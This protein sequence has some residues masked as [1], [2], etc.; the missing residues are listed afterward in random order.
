MGENAEKPQKPY[1]TPISV[2]RPP[3]HHFMLARADIS[4]TGSGSEHTGGSCID[5]LLNI[6]YDRT[7]TRTYKTPSPSPGVRRNVTSGD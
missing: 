1:L 2:G 4:D 6:C 3:C 7:W 5:L